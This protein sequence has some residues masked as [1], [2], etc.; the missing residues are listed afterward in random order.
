MIRNA[1]RPLALSLTLVF[2]AAGQ[3]SIGDQPQTWEQ[4]ILFAPSE[5]T[6]RAE[7]KGRVWILSGLDEREVERAMDE[8][9]DRLAHLLFVNV[10]SQDAGEDDEEDD[11][12]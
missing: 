9:Y 7:A 3:A 2:S 6:L 12:D 4:Q 10:R 8:Q 5:E 1:I 11:C